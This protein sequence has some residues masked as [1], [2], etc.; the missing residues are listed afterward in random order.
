MYPAP[1]ADNQTNAGCHVTPATVPRLYLAAGDGA[2]TLGT[3]HSA[4]IGEYNPL[5]SWKKTQRQAVMGV[6][7]EHSYGPHPRGQSLGHF[8]LIPG[9]KEVGDC[10]C[11][12]VWYIYLNALNVVFKE[13]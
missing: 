8:I 13:V 4:S 3:V 11:K 2:S 9:T 6:H 12:Q 7:S 5:I 10:R 1:S